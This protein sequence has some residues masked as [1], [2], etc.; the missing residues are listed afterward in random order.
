MKL[1][2]AELIRNPDG[3]PLINAARVSQTL[4]RIN[5]EKTKIDDKHIP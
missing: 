2:P 4:K 1:I 3:T 5:V